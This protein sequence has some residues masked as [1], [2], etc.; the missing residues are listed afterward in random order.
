MVEQGELEACMQ[1]F[2]P[3][4]GGEA[5]PTGDARG[6]GGGRA[7]GEEVSEPTRR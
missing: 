5:E 4:I 7:A 3:C 2:T 1:P 6:T